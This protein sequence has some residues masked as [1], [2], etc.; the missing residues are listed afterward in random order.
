MRSRPAPR[1][2]F[3]TALAALLGGLLL[4]S[5]SLAAEDG[6][7]VPPHFLAQGTNRALAPLLSASIRHSRANALHEGAH[8]V[9]ATVRERLAPHFAPETIAA[10]SWTTSSS[11]LTLDGI[12]NRAFP[13]FGAMTF[14][15]VIVFRTRENVSDLSLWAHELVHVEQFRRMGGIGR[16]SHA[17]VAHWPEIEAEAVRR[18]NRILAALGSGRRQSLVGS[19]HSCG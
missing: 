4:G 1:R 18:T 6:C 5:C 16:F 12:V 8:A 7:A 19:P 17:Y 15:N 14:D 3:R 10:A 13:R 11:G 2:R 9:P